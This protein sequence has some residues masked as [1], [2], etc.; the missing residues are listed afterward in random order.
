MKEKNIKVNALL[1]TIKTLFSIIFP[2]ITFP[3]VSRVLM[4]ENIGKINFGTSFVS[5]FSLIA[6]LGITTYAIRECSAKRKSRNELGKI[7]S[8]IFS[9]NICT[10]VIAYAS[11]F[12]TLLFCRSF[13]TYRNLIIIQSTT[14]LFT[15]LGCDWLNTAMEDFTFITIRTIIF[16]LIS[17]IL[18][19]VFVRKP[20]DYIIYAII[21]VLSSSGANI[22]NIFYRKK[23]CNVKF[24]TKMNCRKHIKPISLLF[25][26]IL[27]QT[28]FNSSDITMLG[29][30]KGDY[31]VGLYS[32]AVKMSNLISQ[33]VSSLVWVIMPRM[34]LFFAEENYKQINI[35][36]RK[37]LNFLITLG[38][39]C[40]IG[41]ICLSKEILF[42]ISGESYVGASTALDLLMICYLFGLL[43]GSFL[44]NMVLLPSKREN[45]Y[46]IICCIATIV[47][48]VLNYFLIPIGGANAA[49]FTTAV[50][51]LLILIMLIITKDKRIKIDKLNHIL[52]PPIIG[53]S[54]IVLL[55]SILKFVI[56]NIYVKTIVCI[57]LSSVIY[58]VSQVIMKNEILTD[59][60]LGFIKKIKQ[61][62]NKY[63][64]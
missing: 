6:S 14:I 16:Q 55:C 58:I 59:I 22:T 12:L 53:C 33:I 21:T 27:A 37:I 20:E 13:D 56:L 41:C 62:S 10:T 47:N 48:L 57:L 39:P 64:N 11:M 15:T 5:Y 61:R 4:P 63:R 25:V 31:E 19:F 42:I 60:V 26:M 24:V 32:S 35:M 51:S 52:I 38:F 34:S 46:M 40:A 29:L 54:L 1:N 50:C 3:Y 17:I 49:A 28:V 36:L 23:Y 2:L 45:V 30:M 9:I 7:A 18:M 8:Q 43:G 44:G